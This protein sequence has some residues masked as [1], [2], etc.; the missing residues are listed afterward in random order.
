MDERVAKVHL[1][2]AFFEAMMVL[3]P[4]QAGG[5]VET[6]KGY[7]FIKVTALKEG[8]KV[9]YHEVR[10]RVQVDYREQRAVILGEVFLRGL[11]ERTKITRESEAPKR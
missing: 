9:E 11:M 6:K 5:P 7:H 2:P 1:D 3:K 4:G 10:P 8:R